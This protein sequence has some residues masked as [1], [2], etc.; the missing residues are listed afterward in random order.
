[1]ADFANIGGGTAQGGGT[2]RPRLGLPPVNVPFLLV[3]A[4]LV[5]YGLAIVFSAVSVDEDYSFT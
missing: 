1:M 5:A 2:A 4:L 3:V